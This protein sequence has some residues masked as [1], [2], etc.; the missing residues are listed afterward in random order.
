M[1]SFFRRTIRRFRSKRL[2][3][4]AYK[5]L[6]ARLERIEASQALLRESVG[7]N[8]RKEADRIDG[9]LAYHTERLLTAPQ[10]LLHE[11]VEE[12]IRKGTDRFDGYLAHHTERLLTARQTLLHE[13]VEEAIRK[14]ADRL[15]GYL[16]YHT[17]RLLAR[18]NTQAAPH[19]SSSAAA[20]AILGTNE[21]DVV[22]PT[23]ESGL[24]EY[25]SRH[26]FENIEADVVAVIKAHVQPGAATVDVGSNIGVH[27]LT[28]AATVG[29]SGTVA[30]FE[31][32]PH[33]A[34]A[35]RRTLRL[36]GFSDRTKVYSEAVTDKTGQVTFHRA[37]HGAKSSI[38]SLPD[39]MTAEEIQVPATTLDERITR[40][41]RVDFIKID[42]EGAEPNVWR[43]MRR[44]IA[45]NPELQIALKWSSS[46]FRRSGCDPTAF[47]H[48]ICS[49]GFQPYLIE[50]HSDHDLM[51]PLTQNVNVLE[52]KDLFFTR[53]DL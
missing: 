3:K 32:T 23:V 29:P 21:F 6:L 1:K 20:D 51:Q 16:A 47:M 43:G 24:L 34:T 10:T 8:I 31:P 50:F 19:R 46:E 15:D 39:H 25:I 17:D 52:G 36:N 33:I 45:E 13:V 26:G 9:Y 44:I 49:S 48:D 4:D 40:G 35:L 22:V 28:L 53:R 42:V 7:A 27:A 41:S 2:S 30:C 5:N 18:L 38:F 12:A 14:G 37:H 11:V